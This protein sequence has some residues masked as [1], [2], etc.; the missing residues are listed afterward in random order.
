MNIL[1]GFQNF[2][3][4]YLKRHTLFIGFFLFLSGMCSLIYQIIWTRSLSL[5]FGHTTFAISA[6]ITAFMGGLAL[7]SHYI[8]KWADGEDKIKPFL[9]KH[10]NE[11]LFLAYGILET[12]IGLYCLLTPVLFRGVEAI[13]LNFT[14]LGF[15]PLSLIRFILCLI[16]LIIP[17]FCMGGTLPVISKL[18]I[19]KKA[20]IS[21]GLGFLYF[22]NTIGASFGALVAGFFLIRLWGINLTL[23]FAVITNIAIGILVYAVNKKISLNL[24]PDVPQKEPKEKKQTQE[25]T[26]P[27]T[28]LLIIIFAFTGFASMIFEL[29]WTRALALTLGSSTYAFSAMLTTFLLGIAVGSKLFEN[30]SKRRDFKIMN[31]GVILFCIG[32]F[33]L[34]TTII[35]GYAPLFILKLAP[36]FSNSYFYV[37]MTDFLICFCIMIIPTI[38]MGF[39]FPLA[40]KLYAEKIENLGKN[41]GDIYAVNTLG[42]ILGSFLTG[43]ILIPFWGV[44]NCLR[45]AIL[46]NFC[47]GIIILY[48]FIEKNKTK[49]AIMAISGMT[50]VIFVFFM[51]AWNPAIMS[52]GA[53]LY[54][55][56]YIKNPIPNIQNYFEERRE[57]NLLF[58]KDGISSTVSVYKYEN[59]NSISLQV[60]GKADASTIIDLP[61][62]LL[63]AYIPLL[64]HN[65]PKDILVIGLGSGITAGAVVTFPE[66]NHVKCIEIEPAVIEA[67]KFFSK[68]NR[69]VIKN[70][71]FEVKIGDGRN[72]VLSSN[73][74]YDIIISEPSS[75]WVSGVGYLFTEDFY[76]IALKKLNDG[77]I[78]CQ[79]FYFYSMSPEDFKMVV[80]TFYKVFPKGDIWVGTEADIIMLGSNSD[81]KF[82]YQRFTDCYNKIPDFKKDLDSIKIVEPDIL[83][84]HYITEK[85][86]IEPILKNNRINTD[87]LPIL[88]FSA[89]LYLYTDVE[90]LISKGLYSFKKYFVPMVTNCP[91]DKKLSPSFFVNMIYQL[92]ESGLSLKD[93]ILN[94]GLKQY[95]DNIDLNLIRVNNLINSGQ[96]FTAESELLKMASKNPDNYSIYFTL[97]VLYEKQNQPEKAVEC[98]LRSYNLNNQQAQTIQNITNLLMLQRR[99]NEAE[100]ITNNALKD[101]PANENL[102][103]L[104]GVLFYKKGMMTDAFKVFDEILP[105]TF[106]IE[107]LK[108]LLVVYREQ[109]NYSKIIEVSEKLI[110]CNFKDEQVYLELGKAYSQNGD[111]NKGRYYL[112][113]ALKVDPFNVQVIDAL[114]EINNK[115]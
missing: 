111:K 59:D 81:L 57:K 91:K 103:F 78:F 11:D 75:P 44:Q 107:I 89:P 100:I 66:V 115:Y 31:L 3:T 93:T 79:W 4:N 27:Y 62:Q 8:G 97:G 96:I 50:A 19:K 51:P 54:W 53:F 48:K 26:K 112:N 20:D 63:S 61:T 52:S 22:I 83:F 80:S 99:Y 40:G 65:N 113:E 25:K 9:R 73:S 1:E 84:T 41:I 34:I 64:Y 106:N 6:V 46:I 55:N 85:S 49:Y 88:E 37:L 104:R 102:K 24:E 110:K 18:L 95:P 67:N 38:L 29:A 90:K 32:L 76:R 13:Y 33:S 77:G 69:D 39:A 12:V 30:Q 28:L 60:N 58:Y 36:L 10:G 35:L 15:Y 82:N 71:K 68:F 114:G 16:I 105:K 72:A 109:K 108:N 21:K 5:I 43:F 45:L 14:G 47:A 98:Y 23:T 56:N 86:L 92:K 17:T 94:E 70:P 74:K 2:I 7:G 42:C 101:S 87:N